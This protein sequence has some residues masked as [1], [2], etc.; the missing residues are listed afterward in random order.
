MVERY[1]FQIVMLTQDH[2]LLPF[3][4]RDAQVP[5]LLFALRCASLGVS[6]WLAAYYYANVVQGVERRP[7]WEEL[8][9]ILA[10]CVAL[11]ISFDCGHA[12][13]R[14]SGPNKSQQ[15]DAAIML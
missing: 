3:W 8:F 13:H 7:S 5:R 11:R 15:L 14:S 9:A 1:S 12:L 6:V 10:A 2:E 4:F